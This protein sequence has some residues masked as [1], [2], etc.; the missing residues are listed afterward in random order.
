M[1]ANQRAGRAAIFRAALE[2]GVI[3]ECLDDIEARFIESWKV[4]H[5]ER[6]RNNL[7]RSVH[8]LN[9]LRQQMSMI[10]AGE[11]VTAI[12]RIR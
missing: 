8:I 6:E 1:N 11:P 2:D 5:D 4:T 9:M 3:K 10:V 12:P 7:W